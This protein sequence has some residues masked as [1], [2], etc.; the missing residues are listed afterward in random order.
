M[1]GIISKEVMSKD[2]DVEYHFSAEPYISAACS[3][4]SVLSI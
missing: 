2:V 4:V 1:Y 3:H